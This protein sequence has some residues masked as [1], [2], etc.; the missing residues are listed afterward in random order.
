MS[1]TLDPIVVGELKTSLPYRPLGDVPSRGSYP[2]IGEPQGG[3]V[4]WSPAKLLKVLAD[5]GESDT[6]G[7]FH[8]IVVAVWR[9]DGVPQQ[10][11][12]RRSKCL[13]KKEDRTE[14]GNYRGISLVAHT[15]KVLI[16][17]QWTLQTRE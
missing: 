6:F 13:H 3:R 17:G 14:Y 1:P 15:G 4:R 2:F 8:E 7:K 11:K 12:M 16:A 5:E 9:G 10:W